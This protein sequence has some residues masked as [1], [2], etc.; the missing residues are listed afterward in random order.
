[1]K[2]RRTHCF[3]ELDP[4]SLQR[5]P[6]SRPTHALHILRRYLKNQVRK[7]LLILANVRRKRFI[8]RHGKTIHLQ[9]RTLSFRNQFGHALR[10]QRLVVW[11]EIIV[12][13]NRTHLRNHRRRPAEAGKMP[14]T[15]SH[16]HHSASRTRQVSCTDLGR[17]CSYVQFRNQEF[18]FVK[19][20]TIIGTTKISVTEHSRPTP[21]T[22]PYIV[23]IQVK[24][25][26]P[27]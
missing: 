21:T 11:V 10:S 20:K 22:T 27:L 25:V 1:M 9:R 16:R 13:R 8:N 2:R 23:I 7:P 18:I 24:S 6:K 26:I 3:R 14:T 19:C 17:R 5:S 12:R 4:A 15:V